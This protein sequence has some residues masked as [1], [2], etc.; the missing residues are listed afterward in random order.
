MLIAEELDADWAQ[1][2]IVQ[3]LADTAVFGR[4]VAGGS[5]ATTLQYDAMRRVGAG[6]R[7]MLVQAAAAGW[8]VPVGEVTT[9]RGVLHHKSG[10]SAP[11]GTFAGAAALL[12]PPAPASGV[13]VLSTTV[14][15]ARL[16]ALNT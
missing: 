11:Y 5:M 16:A 15:G 13:T 6:A 7:A 1:V 4:Q 2:D 12:T 9:A 10:R 8:G 3:A 14:C